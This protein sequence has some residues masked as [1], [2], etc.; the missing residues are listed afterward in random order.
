MW[1]SDDWMFEVGSWPSTPTEACN[2]R[3]VSAVKTKM[4]EMKKQV[5]FAAAAVLLL[6]ASCKKE[7]Q[8]ETVCFDGLIQWHGDPAADGLGWVIVK[9]DSTTTKPLVLQNLADS[10]KTDNLKVA[11]C[12]SETDELF[13]CE[14]ARPLNKYHIQSIRRR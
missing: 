5:G 9:D 8:G 6:L 2:R 10:L 1:G 13:Y 11:A 14:C 3:P 7:K 12:I 4:R